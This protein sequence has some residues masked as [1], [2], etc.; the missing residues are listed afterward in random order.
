MEKEQLKRIFEFLEEKENKLTKEK[1]TLR[2]KIVFNE[3]L[4][5]EDL[6]FEDNLFLADTIITSLPEGLK[7]GGW[8]ILNRSSITS[9]PKG[10]KVG[11]Y[12]N[13]RSCQGL[14]SLPEG[15]EVVGD[16]LL[17]NSKN[18]ESLPEGLKVGG[19]LD[20]RD[21]TIGSLPEALKVGANLYIKNTA[22]LEYTDEELREMVKP[23]FIKGYIF[24]R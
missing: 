15:L 14:T 7:V 6:N 11:S 16:L 19:D 20:L 23:G 8:L 3:P 2:W 24:R 10:L 9:L 22:L 4:T 5:K 18:I 12:L 17:Y 1:G 21:T 13:L